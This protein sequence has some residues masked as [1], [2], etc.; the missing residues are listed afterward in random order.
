MQK[1]NI[2]PLPFYQFTA[3][4]EITNEAEEYCKNIQYVRNAFN[5]TTRED[6]QLPNFA[7][8]AT[9]CL[10]KVKQEEFGK[11]L[12]KFYITQIWANR[13]NMAETHHKHGHPNSILS[14]IFYLSDLSKGGETKFYRKNPYHA[15]TDSGYFQLGSTK[16]SE[17]TDTVKSTRG[18]LIIFPS[19]V[20]HS[21][22]PV[23]NIQEARYTIAFN[24]FVTGQVGTK[25][26]LTYLSI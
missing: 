3:S 22:N 23:H 11:T 17:I 9:E 7:N 1:I 18:N 8:W 24:S 14:G 6:V 13:A 19:N 2:L 12:W 5:K 15:L 20:L 10:E 25:E 26:E 16:N 21:V 4:E